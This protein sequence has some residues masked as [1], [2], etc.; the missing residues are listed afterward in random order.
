MW[1]T[2]GNAYQSRCGKNI[3]DYY[4]DHTECWSGDAGVDAVIGTAL[5]KAQ[6]AT[7]AYLYAAD[8]P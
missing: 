2:I 4:R 5:R 7:A 1:N 3:D 6:T 8:V